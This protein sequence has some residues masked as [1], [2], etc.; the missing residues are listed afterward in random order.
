MEVGQRNYVHSLDW[1]RAI[2]ILAVVA[3]HA[4]RF[5]LV[6]AHPKVGS[7][8]QMLFQFGRI[9]FM[10]VT[11][12][13]VAYQYRHRSPRW[14]AFFRRRAKSAAAPYL[15]WLAVFLS[16]SVPLWPM[17]PFWHRFG[18]VLFTGNGHLY[19]L[20]ITFQMYLLAPVLVWALL[21]LSRFPVWLAAAG[22]LWE[23]GSW[24]LAGYF[25]ET[26]W[27]PALWVCTY[28]GYFV[29]GGVLGFHWSRVEEWLRNRRRM[30]TLGLPTLWAL[31]ILT[32]W[33]D[34]R[35]FGGLGRATSMFQPMSALYGMGV[36]ILLLA[37]GTWFEE[38]RRTLPSL[39]QTV[40]LLADASF[41]IYLIHPLFVHGWIDFAGRIGWMPHAV[42]NTT[43]AFLMGV[44]FSALAVFLI[45][46]LPF[47]E[48]II[49]TMRFGRSRSQDA[50]PRGQSTMVAS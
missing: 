36:T 39:S 11:G 30:L 6:P 49:G 26:G 27:A 18:E 19:Y 48:Y 44:S 1:V 37:S 10:V 35:W 22:L 45:R 34:V 29:I 7:L 25:H 41:G 43:I 9:S 13:I 24:T 8:V 23:V 38:A 50:D 16:L 4:I 28:V 33:I 3:V 42:G 17:G 14:L 5:G 2:T 46:R 21:R 31:A 47:S 20:I 12:F 32:F 15:V 40:A